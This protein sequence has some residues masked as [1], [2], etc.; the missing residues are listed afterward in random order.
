MAPDNRCANV[1]ELPPEEADRR[2]PEVQAEV[3]KAL[4]AHLAAHGAED[5]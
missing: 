4:K 3:F 1:E 2:W 5:V